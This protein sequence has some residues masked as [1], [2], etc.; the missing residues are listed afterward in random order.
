MENN[1]TYSGAFPTLEKIEKYF[2]KEAMKKV[3]EN[4]TIAVQLLGITYFAL[5]RRL[6]KIDFSSGNPCS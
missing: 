4:I 5:N 3:K 6:K 2:I 1:I